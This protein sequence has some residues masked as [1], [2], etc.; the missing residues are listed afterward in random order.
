MGVRKNKRLILQRIRQKDFERKCRR[1]KALKQRK[2][3][4]HEVRLGLPI[5]RSFKRI[6]TYNN[7]KASKQKSKKHYPKYRKET[8]LNSV[9]KDTFIKVNEKRVESENIKKEMTMS[10]LI[11]TVRVYG[12]RGLN[13]IEVKLEPFTILTGMNN[14]GKTSFQKALQIVFGNRQ[15]ITHDDFYVSDSDSADK[16]VIDVKIVPINEDGVITDEFEENWNELFTDDRVQIDEEG[17]QLILLRTVVSVNTINNSIKTKQYIQQEWVEF[18]NE[19]GKYWYESNLGMDKGFHFDEVPFFYMDAQ[20]DI[21]EDIK[22]KTSYLGKMLSQI[23]YDDTETQKIE[24]LIKGLN[25]EAVNSSNVLSKIEST[26]KELDTAMD[27]ANNGIQISPFPKKIRDL[28]KGI[29]V[30]YSDFSM[31]YHGMGTR[32]WSSLLILKSFIDLFAETSNDNIKP[33]FPI[34][35]IEEPEAHLHPN[36]QKKLF[37]QISNI[38]GQKIISTHSPYIAGEAELNQIR[39]LYKKDNFVN[40]GQIDIT[41]FDDEEKRKIKRQVVKSRGEL[42]FSK[43]IVLSEGETEEQ[44]LP[45]FAEKYFGKS[46]VEMG[47]DYIGVGSYTKYL[48]FLKVAEYL[49]IPWYI[50]SDAENTPDKQIK[51]NV[52]KQVEKSGTSREEKDCLIFLDDGNDFEKQLID[53]GYQNEIK[54]VIASFEVYQSEEHK[55]YREPIRKQEI[56]KYNDEKLYEIITKGK[57]QY[58]PAIAQQIVCND[59]DLPQKVTDLFDKIK[60]TLNTQKNED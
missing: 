26:L 34:V 8:N 51:D 44:A 45:I 52:Q 54:E 33:F 7:S 42:F 9:M 5:P 48:P 27:N 50:F 41:K 28:L 11:D 47:I 3:Q 14:A 43:V 18:K 25:D 16:I 24:T 36:A 46:P 60:E 55:K 38:Q 12:F 39:N 29:S 53:D 4:Y 35:A 13:N 32:S 1:K 40:C 19:S 57:T 20:R 22:A 21:V 58:G 15:F 37:S 10:I 59:K 49:N 31:E 2:I 56:D 23:K 6:K 30:Q 17:N